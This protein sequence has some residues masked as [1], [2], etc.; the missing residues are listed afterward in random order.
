MA[1]TPFPAL[2]DLQRIEWHAERMA[3]VTAIAEPN[4]ERIARAALTRLELHDHIA[5]F[6]VWCDTQALNRQ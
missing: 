4:N 3:A 2:V 6:A 1:S 5:C